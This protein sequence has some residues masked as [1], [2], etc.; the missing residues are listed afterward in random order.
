LTGLPGLKILRITYTGDK[1]TPEGIER[2]KAMMPQLKI[3]GIRPART[4]PGIP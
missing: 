3:A 4:S 1:V 2:L